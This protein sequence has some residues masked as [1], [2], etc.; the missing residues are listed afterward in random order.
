MS[1]SQ[2]EAMLMKGSPLWRSSC[3]QH[4]GEGL[5]PCFLHERF[6]QLT[7]NSTSEFLCVSV[8]LCD[9]AKVHETLT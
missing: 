3:E 8:V 5:T 9:D 7:G 1:L 6:M 2:R 4:N